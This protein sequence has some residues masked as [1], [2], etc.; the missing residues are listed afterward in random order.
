[1]TKAKEVAEKTISGFIKERRAA[2]K[3]KE[4]DAA[5]FRKAAKL[6]AKEKRGI[7]LSKRDKEFLDVAREID[8]ERRK[9]PGL[10]VEAAK[11]QK[12]IDALAEN[13]KTLGEI[14][15]LLD[16]NLKE[17]QALSKLG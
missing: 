9:L 6:A 3:A 5:E 13:T 12:Q 4:K 17:Q 14:K 11:A 10:N 16:D 2:K 7:R 15:K 1:M 8:K